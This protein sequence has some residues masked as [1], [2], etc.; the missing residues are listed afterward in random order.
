MATK[1]TKKEAAAK[2]AVETKSKSAPKPKAAKPPAPP[3]KAAVRKVVKKAPVRAE[4]PAKTVPAKDIE[5]R[6]YFL[7]MEREASGM[8]PSPLDDWLAAE[9]ELLD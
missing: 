3:A 9:R 6:A 5:V 1:P 2:P 8:P 7:A 4:K